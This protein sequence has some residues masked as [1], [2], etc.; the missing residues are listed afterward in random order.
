MKDNLR[1]SQ[2][3]DK[4]VLWSHLHPGDGLKTVIENCSQLKEKQN[5]KGNHCRIEV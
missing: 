3:L 2:E 4:E 1:I 5:K